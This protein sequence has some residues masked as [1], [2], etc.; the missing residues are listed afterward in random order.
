MKLLGQAV[1]LDSNPVYIGGLLPQAMAFIAPS[2][3]TDGP[4]EPLT[5]HL[6]SFNGP[7][8]F[9]LLR[10]KMARIEFSHSRESLSGTAVVDVSSPQL[11]LEC[12]HIHPELPA[13]QSKLA[14]RHRNGT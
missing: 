6:A 2:D 10:K 9:G 12:P 1:P 3:I 14:P 4:H 5:Q 8:F 7:G 13:I 11:T